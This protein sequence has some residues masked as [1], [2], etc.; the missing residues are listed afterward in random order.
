RGE[1]K[2]GQEAAG[3]A[4]PQAMPILWNHAPAAK[5]AKD[6]GNDRGDRSKGGTRRPSTSGVCEYC[7]FSL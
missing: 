4:P 7:L 3:D 1:F 6:G 5:I 2:P